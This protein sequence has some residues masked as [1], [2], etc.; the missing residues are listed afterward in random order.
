MKNNGA[1][2]GSQYRK[3]NLDL[4]SR[5]FDNIDWEYTERKENNK[6]E[7]NNQTRK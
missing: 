3:V 4:Y 2:K 7:D 6:K 1:G 5:N